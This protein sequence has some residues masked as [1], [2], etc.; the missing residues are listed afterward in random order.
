[1]KVVAVATYNTLPL[2]KE[3]HRL[4]QEADIKAYIHDESWV[5]RF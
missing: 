1:M 3:L 4:L 5:E 2:A